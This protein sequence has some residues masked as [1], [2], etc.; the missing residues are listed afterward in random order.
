VRIASTLAMRTPT[1]ALHLSVSSFVTLAAAGEA[2][3]RVQGST[4]LAVAAPATDE[5]QVRTILGAREKSMYDATH[6][7]AAW[8]L[9]NG[10][11][12]AV[13][14]GE[15]SGSAGAPILAAIDGAE[16]TD[17]VVVVTRYYGGTKLGVGGL[18]RAYGDAAALAL[19]VAPQRVGTPASR[20]RVRYPYEH[21]AAMMRT[22]ERAEARDVEHGYAAGGA[23]GE[24]EF[25]VPASAEDSVAT[26]L[27]D[28]TAGAVLPE[29]VGERILY[30]VSSP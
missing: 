16:L 27:R 12:R 23:E 4:F 3:T 26:L 21:T 29:R 6:H 24:V 13:D 1:A 5:V 25:S 8:R 2:E 9:R 30:D 20:L 19:R 22:L 7:C 17:C 11:W 18:I 10:V 14:A 28:T 15:P